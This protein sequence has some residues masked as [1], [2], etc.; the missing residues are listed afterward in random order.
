VETFTIE[1]IPH[2]LPLK[3][4]L[5]GKCYAGKKTVAK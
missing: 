3:L 1:G 2:Y 5:L 4:A